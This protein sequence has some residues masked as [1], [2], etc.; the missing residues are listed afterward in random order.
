MKNF[1]KYCFDY[2]KKIPVQEPS[3]ISSLAPKVL[4]E[5]RDI[6]KIQPYLD[7]L[8]ETIDDPSINNIALTGGYGSG[9]ST[10]LKTFQANNPSY[11]YLN[12]SLASFKDM[13]ASQ[14][15]DANKTIDDRLERVLEVSILQQIFY[16]VRPEE[17]PDSRFKRIINTTTRIW[18]V[19]LAFVSWFISVLIL[20]KLNY[21]DKLNP[22]TWNLKFSLDYYALI[23]H[24]I[25]FLGIGLFA[26]VVVRLFTNSKINK[27][28]IKGELE[29]GD[30]LDKSV[31]NEHLEE[32]LYFFER[33]DY[34]VVIIEDLDRFEST[35][36]FTKLREL[37]ILINNSKSISQD[38]NFVYAIKD[39]MFTDKSER[40]KFFEYIIPVIPFVNPSN[41]GEQM[42]RLIN[43]AK[44]EN[45]LSKEFTEDVVT[46][47]D[48]IDM[49]LLTNIFHEYQLY[50]TSLSSDLNQDELFAMITYKNLFPSDF[51]ELSRRRG[52]LYSVLS[53]KNNYITSVVEKIEE[54]IKS[55]QPKIEEIQRERLPSLLELRRLYINEYLLQLPGLHSLKVGE[56]E[57]AHKDLNTLYKDEVFEELIKQR[58]IRFM[59]YQFDYGSTYYLRNTS[60]LISF[61]KI[62]SKVDSQRSYSERKKILISKSTN[63]QNLFKEEIQTLKD[64]RAEVEAWSIKKIFENVEYDEYLEDFKDSFLIRNLIIN[65]Y[66]NENYNDY[67]S[68]FHAVNITQE[69]NLF[70]RNIKS[71]HGLAFDYR[72]TKVENVYRKIGAKYFSR[73]VVLNFDLLNYMAENYDNCQDHYLL[74]MDQFKT[75]K[76]VNYQFIDDY[77]NSENSNKAL[78]IN[79]MCSKSEGFWNYISTKSNYPENKQRQ[80][81]KLIFE[82][83]EI[84]DILQYKS[85]SNILSFFENIGEYSSICQEID[86]ERLNNIFS[87]LDVKID[88]LQLPEE[89]SIDLFDFIYENNYYK[90]N[91]KNIET[92]F[93]YKEPDFDFSKLK[94]QNF[95]AISSSENCRGLVQY[96]NTNIETYVNDVL[97]NIKS[98]IEEEQIPLKVILNHES[99]AIDLRQSLI[100]MQN[101]VIE[102]ISDIKD[103]EIVSS[104]IIAR[105]VTNNWKNFE[106]YFQAFIEE[107]QLDDTLINYLNEEEVYKELTQANVGNESTSDETIKNKIKVS[108]LLCNALESEAYEAL[109]RRI[110]GR[111]RDIDF[112]ELEG[113]KVNILIRNNRLV[114]NSAAFESMVASH[115]ANDL[116]VKFI[117]NNFEE[118]LELID[119]L[120]LEIDSIVKIL[121]SDKV[122]HDGLIKMIKL[123]EQEIISENPKLARIVCNLLSEDTEAFLS[124]ATLQNILMSSAIAEK[125]LRVLNSH[126]LQLSNYEIVTFVQSLGEEYEN[127]FIKRRRPT[128]TNNNDH[129]KLF[130]NL[131][132]RGLIKTFSEYSGDKDLIRV[133]ANYK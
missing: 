9:K 55:I 67:I 18:W 99:L 89:G 102:D 133:V 78:L 115:S 120:N 38:V 23:I 24:I 114:F 5:E 17:I 54:Q 109:I 124:N 81:L 15:T 126:L 88:V 56:V 123:I 35:D 94:T 13:N 40:V 111:W 66:L 42:A 19:S 106:V 92:I 101:F 98:M 12:I 52:K 104:L 27:L 122:P 116:P 50:R 73:N 68:L 64:K 108:I 11:R 30:N 2:F 79:K 61:A 14:G 82:H 41:A 1:V 87:T 105:N 91:E 117:E 132:K 45:V 31:F 46:F 128:F 20:F 8:K 93:H 22:Q 63:E 62:E 100:E 44:L 121:E 83:A 65:G 103:D 28:N 70:L 51:G 127:I 49:R 112:S 53:S 72:L 85:N 75:H 33:T 107:N 58:E 37:N 130:S 86:K 57:I 59:Q 26:K 4:K 74:I 3:S 36:I 90:I 84:D 113:D 119:E 16:H 10:I 80:Y 43:E 32:I 131:L 34:N 76:E 77:I 60:I 125:K 71:G 129:V 95:S 48:D 6:Q 39:E 69:D 7:K 96:V 97:L 25:F 118:F 21:I 29:L 47:I 110:P